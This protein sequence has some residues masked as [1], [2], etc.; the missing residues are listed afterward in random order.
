MLTA[1]KSSLTILAESF[2]QK[3][4]GKIFEVQMWIQILTTAF[5]QIFCKMIFNIQVIVE[6]II[7]PD[8]NLRMFLSL[9]PEPYDGEYEA[10]RFHLQ[11]QV[12]H[13]YIHHPLLKQEGSLWGEDQEVPPH[14]LFPRIHRWAM[15]VTNIV[16]AWLWRLWLMAACSIHVSPHY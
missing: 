2:G 15:N 9:S 1:A 3:H 8:D 5:L 14:Q 16:L 7:Y 10:V 12:V 6:S 4:N 11:Q 13:G